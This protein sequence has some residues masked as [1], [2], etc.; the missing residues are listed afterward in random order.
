MEEKIDEIKLAYIEALDT[1]RKAFKVAE[2]PDSLIEVYLTNLPSFDKMVPEDVV[3]IFQDMKTAV[4]VYLGGLGLSHREIE[5]RL[6]GTSTFV[7]HKILK[8]RYPKF[9]QP[10]EV[11]KH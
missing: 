5:R 9:A 4:I 11:R 6:G 1:F 8:E 10:E 2:V 7:V 3:Q